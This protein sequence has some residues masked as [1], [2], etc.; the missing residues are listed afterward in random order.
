MAKLLARGVDGLIIAPCQ[1][2]IAPQLL[3]SRKRTP[4]VM[5]DR[6]YGLGMFPTVVSD[7]GQGGL[8]M[9]RRMLQETAGE[10]FPF[11]AVTPSRRASRIAFAASRQRVSSAV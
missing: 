9:T 3:K 1:P 4:V 5:F 10:A 7:N 11:S 6:D 8:E 2:Q